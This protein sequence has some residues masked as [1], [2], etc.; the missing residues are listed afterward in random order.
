VIVGLHQ[1]LLSHAMHVKEAKDATT[2]PSRSI[3]LPQVE[4]EHE[5]K[6]NMEMKDRIKMA[7]LP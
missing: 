7:R 1:C 6:Q 3:K 5:A 4:A 2:R